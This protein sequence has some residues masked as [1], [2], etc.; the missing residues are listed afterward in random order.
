VL[1]IV[2]LIG[3]MVV[4]GVVVVP[5]TVEPEVVPPATVVV[6]VPAVVVVEPAMKEI[7]LVYTFC[8]QSIDHFS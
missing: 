3:A 1:Q 6:V 4:V 7:R 8:T 5:A 2:N